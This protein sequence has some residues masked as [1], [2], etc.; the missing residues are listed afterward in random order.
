MLLIKQQPLTLVLHPDLLTPTS[1]FWTL[2]VLLLKA[3]ITPDREVSPRGFILQHKSHQNEQ[4]YSSGQ[5]G[6]LDCRKSECFPAPSVQQTHVSNTFTL[7]YTLT[8]YS[9]QM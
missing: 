1:A 7:S 5:C 6:T 4:Q 9:L 3:V 2:C 8:L